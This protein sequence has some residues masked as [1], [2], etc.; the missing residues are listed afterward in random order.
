MSSSVLIDIPILYTV[1]GLVERGE[2]SLQDKVQIHY[3]TYGRGVLSQADDGSYRTVKELLSIMFKHS[4]NNA[5][6]S[7]MDHLTLRKINSFCQNEGY[8]SVSAANRIGETTDYTSS[9][10]YVSARDLCWMLY[11]LYNSSGDLNRD[12]LLENLSVS[13]GTE[14]EGLNKYFNADR[15]L[16]FNGMKAT[17]Y[18]EILIVEKGSQAYAI[19]LLSNNA[20][21]QDLQKIAATIGSYISD[22]IG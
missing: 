13:D 21:L 10:N 20:N 14:A 1:S 8:F 7:F 3:T 19:A 18:N 9:D 15:F 17:K 11:E 5:T 22:S 4:D 16:C 2:L 12:F 6:N